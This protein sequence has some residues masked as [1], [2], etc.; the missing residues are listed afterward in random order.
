[1][2]GNPISGQHNLSTGHQQGD[3]SV[4][5]LERGKYIEARNRYGDKADFKTEQR[6]K[7]FASTFLG[8]QVV[9]FH[10]PEWEVLL[11]S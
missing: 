6:A 4:V 5:L 7:E 2:R 8:A 11:A 3:W 10:T 1:M 9:R